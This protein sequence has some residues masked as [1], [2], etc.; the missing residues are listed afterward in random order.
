M[1]HK[2]KKIKFKNGQD[3]NRMIMRKLMYNFLRDSRITTTEARAKALKTYMDR[4]VSKAKE[5]T[6]SNKNYLLKFFNDQKI[7]S[8]L[9]DQVG[10]AVTNI[11]GGFVKIVRLNQRE[12]DAAMMVQLLWAH[13]VVIDWG[14]SKPEPIKVEKKPVA[15]KKTTKAKETK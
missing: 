7:I 2:T 14:T 11:N 1:I 4:V 10:P 15:K 13:P 6:E 3:S 5:R 12:N 8:V 9:F